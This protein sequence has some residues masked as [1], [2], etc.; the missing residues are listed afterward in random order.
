MDKLSRLATAGIP[1]LFVISY[2]KQT[3]IAESL[4]NLKQFKVALHSKPSRTFKKKPKLQR[5]PIDFLEYKKAFDQVI[6]KIKAGNTYLLNLTFSTPIKCSFSLEEIFEMANAPYK[7]LCKEKFVCFS[8]EPFIKIENNVISTYPMKGTI[9]ATV[10]NAKEKILAN[11]KEMAEHVMVVDLLRNDLGIVGKNVRVKKFRY[12]DKIVTADKT[13]LQV[14][15]KIEAKL[16]NDWHK[17]LGEILDA[18]LPAGSITGTPK[19]KTCEIIERV[20]T[21]KRGFFTG[22]FGVYDGKNLE[23]AVMIRFIE[24]GSDGLVYKSGGG[25]TID[26]NAKAEYQ[27][28]LDKVYLPI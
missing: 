6:E 23:S 12:I 8:P 4:D 9:D 7:L 26:S 25:I 21:H 16:S 15:S 17:H 27:E 28:M 22:V 18:I 2:D 5:S 3:V 13:L 1:F 19:Q 20:E 10:P 11:E 14:S 24:Q